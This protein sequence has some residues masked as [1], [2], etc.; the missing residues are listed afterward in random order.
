MNAEQP[1]SSWR[2]YG[3]LGLILLVGLLLRFW[4]LDTKPLWLDEVI[5]ALISLRAGYDNVPLGTVIPLQE[6]VDAF[7]LKPGVTC[8]EIARALA[9]D[10]THPPLF[11]CG[12][13]RWLVM[14]EDSGHSLAWQIR[15]LPALFGVGAI[16]AL[17]ALNR[18]AFS[19]SV[20]LAGAALM[21]VSPFGIYLS[22]E[23]R[24]YTLPVVTITL[25]LLALLRIQQQLLQQ[26]RLCPWGWGGWVTAN[27]VGLYVHYFCLLAL[28]AQ[29]VT[30]VGSWGYQ[31]CRISLRVWSAL[32]LALATITLL[33][34]PW[35]P[36]F[37]SH[38]NRPE[39]SWLPPPY[40]ISPF[41]QTFVGW[42]LMVAILPVEH[43]PVW[44][45]V[46]CGLLLLAIA[47]WVGRTAIAGLRQS[48]RN[49]TTHLATLTL[50]GFTGCVVLE[51]F[52][53]AYGLGKDL[54]SVPRYNFAYFPGVCALLAASLSAAVRGGDGD[55]EGNGD[56]GGVE[57]IR[58]SERFNTIPQHSLYQ[59]LAQWNRW[60]P[61]TVVVVAGI[62]GSLVVASGFAFYKPFLPNQIARDL[63]QD[64]TLPL[65]V[66]V[67]HRDFQ[68]VALGLSIALAL[69]DQSRTHLPPD[70]ASIAWAF[71]DREHGNYGQVWDT[72]NQ[73]PPLSPPPLD[74]WVIAPNL[75]RRHYP[76]Q[77]LLA[78]HP[79]NPDATAIDCPIDP[80]HHY[81]IGI[82]Y[83]RYRCGVTETS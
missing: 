41:Y 59:W 8:P 64:P 7:V 65:E 62:I 72:L 18:F 61:L 69:H 39:T 13:H 73:L 23:A 15:S 42:L 63:Q 56:D 57:R 47:A 55:D 82:P 46:P 33:Y 66:V 58:N 25:A 70:N 6:V 35:W 74:L 17:Y 34:W 76:L 51:F 78:G 67:S 44:I 75:R 19:R 60:H 40:N 27:A 83:Q 32:G 2:H 43:Q 48:W 30:L 3:L 37:F 31:R 10:S 52:A 50:A 79:D 38:F 11:F 12:L 16:A 77:L 20:G 28:V 80:Q 49:P 68:D 54:T 1:T 53:I 26:Q 71:L 14:L 36:I 24:H 29:V 45:S 5:T 22:Q 81:R 4:Q 9:T 21:A